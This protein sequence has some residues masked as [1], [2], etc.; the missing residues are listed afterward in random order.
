M[1]LIIFI[2]SVRPRPS[3][4]CAR[5]PDGIYKIGW[6]IGCGGAKLLKSKRPIAAKLGDL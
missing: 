5:R 1:V 2:D 4:I 6:L 3:N